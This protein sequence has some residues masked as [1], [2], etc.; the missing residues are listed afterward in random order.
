MRDNRLSRRI[1]RTVAHLGTRLICPKEII[2]VPIHRRSNR[3]RNKPAAAI[4]TDISQNL[5]DTGHAERALIRADARLKRLLRQ[6]PV[7]MLAGRSEFKYGALDVKLP[8]MGNQWFLEIFSSRTRSG[9][10]LQDA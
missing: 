4:G 9:P 8:I 3:S 7:A 10:V 2:I 6:R 1:H 5:F